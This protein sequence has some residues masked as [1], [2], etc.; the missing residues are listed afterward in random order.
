MALWFKR[1]MNTVSTNNN[2][3]SV[4]K[5]TKMPLASVT[6]IVV[7]C[8]TTP[9]INEGYLQVQRQQTFEVLYAGRHKTKDEDWFFVETCQDKRRGWIPKESVVLQ[10]PRVQKKAD[11]QKDMLVHAI[12]ETSPQDGGY[13]KLH[14]GDALKVLYVGSDETKDKDWIF[15]KDELSKTTGWTEKANCQPQMLTTPRENAALQNLPNILLAQDDIPSILARKLP[16]QHRAARATLNEI[17]TLQNNGGQCRTFNLGNWF[18]W[19]TYI[20]QH[21]EARKIIGT[22]IIAA[23]CEYVEGE[24]DHNREYRLRTDFFSHRTDGTYCRMHP[25]SKTQLDAKLKFGPAR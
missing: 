10:S 15:A 18:E 9:A 5:P 20:A 14:V 1:C 4:E 6:D 17:D 12:V 25:G 23:T 22:G 2:Y 16:K 8:K 11:F 3:S 7:G 13:L 21:P 24:T 19:R